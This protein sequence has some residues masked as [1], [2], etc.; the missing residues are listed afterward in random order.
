VERLGTGTYRVVTPNVAPLETPTRGTV[1]LTSVN[2]NHRCQVA[3]WGDAGVDVHCRSAEG[4]LADGE[5]TL[6]IY[7]E[8]GVWDRDAGYTL[9]DQF[10]PL[11][12]GTARSWNARGGGVSADTVSDSGGGH[13]YEV[14]L[15]ALVPS[16]NYFG[17]ATAYGSRDSHCSVA[18]SGSI[19]WVRCADR[20]TGFD[21]GTDHPTS[22]SAS[23]RIRILLELLCSTEGRPGSFRPTWRIATLRP[24]PFLSIRSVLCSTRPGGP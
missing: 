18:S 23:F 10:A 8:D 16:P 9:V 5:F 14:E 22:P 1:H 20:A 15:T 6:L 11:A 2:G 24:C 7:V 19:P 13:A 3:E 4:I 12:P 21:S 17:L